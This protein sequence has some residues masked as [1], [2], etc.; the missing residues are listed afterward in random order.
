MAMCSA[1]TS[2]AFRRHY[3]V[4][5]YAEEVCTVV[6]V[7]GGGLVILP[8]AMRHAFQSAGPG[9]RKLN[10]CTP[11]AMVGSFEE[12]AAAI[13]DNVGETGLDALAE[14]YQMEIVGPVPEGYL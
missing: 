13:A 9:S 10:L 6:E 3:A 11:A 1:L 7:A 5:G 4:S 12:F 14:R 8:V 2:E